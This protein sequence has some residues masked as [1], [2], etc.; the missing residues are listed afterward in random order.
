MT[1]LPEIVHLPYESEV[2]SMWYT[3]E[4]DVSVGR[5]R[6]AG[7][8]GVTGLRDAFLVLFSSTR[9]KLTDHWEI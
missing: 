4:N 8:F 5:R 1:H 9:W 6:Y 7:G 2:I 3:A